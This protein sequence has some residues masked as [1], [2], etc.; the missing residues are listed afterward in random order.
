MDKEYNNFIIGKRIAIVAH[1]TSIVGT[2]QGPLID[3]YDFVVRVN[4]SLPIP[5]DLKDDIGTRCDVLYSHM[6]DQP[7]RFS[8]YRTINNIEVMKKVKW[9]CCPHPAVRP[10]VF[11]VD[12]LGGSQE[13]HKEIVSQRYKRFIERM[14]GACCFRETDPD[15]YAKH[16]ME[17]EGGIPNVGFASVWDLLSFDISELYMAGFTFFLG[18]NYKQYSTHPLTE[19]E[20]IGNTASYESGHHHQIYPQL[21]YFKKLL[22]ED[23]RITIDE[24]LE[25]V[26][27]DFKG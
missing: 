24:E 25:K 16:L 22:V 13:T 8:D 1:A 7:N 3:S 10:P 14:G 15:N 6:D 26:L 5:E 23:S 21:R 19:E 17:M 20:I 18:G 12:F 4:N 11:E 9:V 2:K 27:L